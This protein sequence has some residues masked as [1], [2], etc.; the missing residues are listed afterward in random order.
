MP[1]IVE[2]FSG[3]AA[4]R[5]FD[6]PDGLVATFG[7]TE[8][9]RFVIADDTH[10]S[11]MHF[12][13][14]CKGEECKIRD[15]GSTNGTFLNGV[16]ITESAVALGA[17]ISAGSCAF[18]LCAGAPEEWTD[19]SPRLR[20]VLS[21]LYSDGQ[22]VYAVLDAAQEDRLPAFLKAYSVEHS[23]L[24][25]GDSGEQMKDVAPYVALLPKKSQLLPLLMKE[26]WGRSWGIYLNSDA[27][28]TKVREHLRRLLT[29]KDE[30]GRLLYFRFY[31]PRVLRVFIPTCTPEESKEFFG[32]ISRFV[33]EGDNPDQ[34]LQFRATPLLMRTQLDQ[35]GLPR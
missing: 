4:G 24:Y 21:L 15:L 20:K 12:S 11:G 7:R 34:P 23:S 9:S 30:D 31:D 25:E 2:S 22:P 6:L 33:V 32:L 26:G 5:K 17:V 18:K 13:L 19:F 3:P 27:D 28:L 16:R 29:V 10:L 8:K 1:F 35:K 14:E